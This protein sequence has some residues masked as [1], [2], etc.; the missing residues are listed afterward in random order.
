[1]KGIEEH[2]PWC[3]LLCS[4]VLHATCQSVNKVLVLPLKMKAT[5]QYMYFH[6]V[7]FTILYNAVPPF[8]SLDEILKCD[9]SDER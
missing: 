1:M 5:D 4:V 3:S 9:H 2:F 6:V 7:L 8:E